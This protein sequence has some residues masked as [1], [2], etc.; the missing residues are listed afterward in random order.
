MMN[1]KKFLIVGLGLLGGSYALA[2]KKW[3]HEVYAIDIDPNAIQYALEHQI[4]DEGSCENDPALIQ[5]ADVIISGLYPKDIVQWIQNNQQY[6][7]P[8]TL[9]SDVTGVKCA[10]LYDIQA[11]LRDDCEFIG[12]HP[13]AGKEVSGVQHADASIFLPANL[14]LTPTDK[15]TQQA[16]DFMYE[17]GKELRFNN[18]CILTPEKHDE[19]IG[20]LSQLTHVIAVSLMNANDN[21]HLKEYTGDSFRDLTRIAKINE[22]LWTELFLMNKE[23]LIHEIDIFMDEMKSF[24][25]ILEKEDTQAMKEKF[26]QSTQRRKYFD[27]DS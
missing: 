22:N 3:H 8:N 14:I 6:F 26:I 18:I 12:S 13:M 23:N 1:N 4:I 25:D 24:R 5:K 7:K 15:N 11:I 10:V 19:M 17:F 27:I 21:K 9:I 16:I 2:L 20:Y